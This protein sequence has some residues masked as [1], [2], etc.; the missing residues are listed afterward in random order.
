PKRAGSRCFAAA[1]CPM[2]RALRLLPAAACSRLPASA[3]RRNSSR[4][5]APPG[6]TSRAPAA[7]PLLTA[8]RRRKPRRSL[9]RPTARAFLWS[10]RKRISCAFRTSARLPRWRHAAACCRSRSKSRRK[11]ASAALCWRRSPPR[12]LRSKSLLKGAPPSA[13]PICLSGP[14]GMV[15][16]QHRLGGCVGLLQLHAPVFQFLE[17]DGHS[18][19][20]TPHEGAGPHHPEVA[21]EV[22]DLGLVR[23]GR[24]IV[25][26]E[27]VRKPSDRCNIMAR[28]PFRNPPIRDHLPTCFQSR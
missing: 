10:R 24:A 12:A 9:P 28:A 17:R 6:S 18:R 26:I 7:F 25:A 27:H 16:A 1:S 2:P 5:S 23:H 11:I 22:L 3:I 13:R 8:S 19:D 20:R 14:L 4:R 21:V 15:A